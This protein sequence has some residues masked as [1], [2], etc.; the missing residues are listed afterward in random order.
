MF[1]GSEANQ[2]TAKT[3]SKQHKIGANY[4]PF[5]NLKNQNETDLIFNMQLD[6]ELITESIS[7]LEC[8]RCDLKFTI[9]NYAIF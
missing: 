1:P 5:L 9:Q 8:D 6:L 7:A 3:K 2:R 4:A